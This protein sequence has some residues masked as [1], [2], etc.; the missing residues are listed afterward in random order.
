MRMG[1]SR[2][3]DLDD[4]L[5]DRQ[6]LQLVH[7]PETETPLKNGGRGERLV[8]ISSEFVKLLEDHIRDRRIDTDDRYAVFRL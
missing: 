1:G 5:L 8:A 6:L 3:L 4:V 7:R 2:A